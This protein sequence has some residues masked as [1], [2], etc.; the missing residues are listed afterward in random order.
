M[1]D[2]LVIPMLGSPAAAGL[3][4]TLTQQRL[5]K[6]D[7]FHIADDVQLIVAELIANAAEA[8]PCKEIRFQL[9]RDAYGVVI[10]VWDSSPA[11][12]QPKPVVELTLDD[13]DLSPESFD[14]N[15]GWGLPIVQTLAS[16]CGYTPDPS[17]GKWIWARMHLTPP[18]T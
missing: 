3:A 4:R 8:T 2:D 6:W 12:P 10:A 14:D 17:G 9:S 7:C 16:Q 1:T 13:L 5:H 18:H 15:G 11:L